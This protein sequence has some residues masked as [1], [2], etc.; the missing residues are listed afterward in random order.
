MNQPTKRLHLLGS[1]ALIAVGVFFLM[2]SREEPRQNAEL[3]G[4]AREAPSAQAPVEEGSLAQAKEAER[5][6]EQIP[7]E[8]GSDVEECID[9]LTLW[10]WQADA[11]AVDMD[12]YIGWM[13][14][15]REGMAEAAT[16]AVA[17]LD[18]VR[19]QVAD[20]SAPSPCRE[21]KAA[22]LGAIDGLRHAFTEVAATK[23]DEESLDYELIRARWSAYNEQMERFQPQ[24]AA[25]EDAELPAPQPDFASAKD[26]EEYGRALQFMASAQ[27]RE[28]YALLTGLQEKHPDN[29]FLLVRRADCL[30]RVTRDEQDLSDLVD[31]DPEEEAIGLLNRAVSRD[32]YS[33]MLFEAWL[34][35]RTLSQPG[36]SNYSD[37]PNWDF[38]LKRSRLVEIIRGHLRQHPNDRLARDQK[39]ALV[40]TPNIHRGGMMGN[41]NLGWWGLLFAGDVLEDA[42]KAVHE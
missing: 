4:P 42:L 34:K 23:A 25:E 15:D 27:Y 8:P 18:I 6:I 28:A 41:T 26:T 36:V 29:E 7:V 22:L 31:G 32:S 40:Q 38:N 14:D 13:S 24:P 19:G 12:L 11:V 39:E 3:A 1:L 21:A 9:S 16:E 30:A 17:R 33:P 10:V 2:V 35:W 20:L 37:I 5:E